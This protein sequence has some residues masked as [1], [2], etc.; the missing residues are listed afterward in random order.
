MRMCAWF[1]ACWR[2][3]ALSEGLRASL[4][5]SSSCSSR[6]ELGDSDE[7]VSSRHQVSMHLHSQASTIA[8][9]AQT[10]DRLHPAKRLLDLLAEQL[11]ERI[12]RMAYRASVERRTTGARMILRDVRSDPE[13]TAGRDEVAGIV[14]LIT[15]Q[16]DAPLTRQPLIG[17]RDRGAPFGSAIGGLHL[18][19]E[20]Q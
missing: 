8:S 19:V 3:V 13:R 17:H 1:S 11:T 18:E 14:T 16:G 2:Q 15:A 5:A 7:V 9:L 12:T 6:A 10:A 4:L 20:Q